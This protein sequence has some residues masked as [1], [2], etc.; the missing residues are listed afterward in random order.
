LDHANEL[1]FNFRNNHSNRTAIIS[2]LKFLA[3]TYNTLD[4]SEKR[5]CY[6]QIIDIETK[7]LQ[8]SSANRNS[9]HKNIKE[10]I[11]QLQ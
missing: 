10:A 9:D 4:L 1:G 7:Y 2:L 5:Y 8:N 3:N 6:E 11:L